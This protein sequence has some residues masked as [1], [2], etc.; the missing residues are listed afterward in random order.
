MTTFTALRI[1]QVEKATQ[2]RFDTITVDD[3]SAGEVVI[4]VA[5]SSLNYKDALAVTGKGRI[6]RGYPKVAGI[7]LSG[8]VESSSD[9]QFKPGDAVLVTGCNIGE[10][11]DGGLAEFA[12]VA[13]ASV[14]PLPNGLGRPATRAPCLAGP[15][16]NRS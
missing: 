5:Y 14:V 12:R 15:S 4:R 8:H 2:A 3:L 1:H 9:P 13:A 6:M 7:D 16:G 10:A 11:L